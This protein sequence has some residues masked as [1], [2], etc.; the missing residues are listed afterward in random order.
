MRRKDRAMDNK[1]I[2]SFLNT[3]A[4]GF[5]ATTHN[6]QPL[7][8]IN[9]FIYDDKT[10][11]LFMHTAKQSFFKVTI[12]KDNRVSFA[13]AEMGRLLPAKVAREMSVEYDSVIV[14]G[15]ALVVDDVKLSRDK[16]QMFID[17]YFP[18][19]T[20]GEDYRPM[21]PAELAEIAVYQIK[22]DSWSGKRKEADKDFNGAFDYGSKKCPF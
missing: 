4:F 20:S 14:I 3:A 8:T 17:K 7:Q 5:L 11:S 13:A 16:M 10:H 21:T 6:G 1:A 15:H 12:E 22:I 2:A 18:H 9:T 19:L